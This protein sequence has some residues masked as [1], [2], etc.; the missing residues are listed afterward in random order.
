MSKSE[1]V[2][3]AMAEMRQRREKAAI[4]RDAEAK[5]MQ[6]EWASDL[7]DIL[8]ENPHMEA[9]TPTVTTSGIWI[10]LPECWPIQMWPSWGGEMHVTFGVAPRVG[11]DTVFTG[12][13][14]AAIIEKAHDAFL[15]N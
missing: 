13:D 2:E 15:G 4:E 3:D 6:E 9:Y 11:M 1:L 7:A 14:L 10:E 12:Q 8:K 5:R